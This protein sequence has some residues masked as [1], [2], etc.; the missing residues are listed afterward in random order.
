MKTVRWPSTWS[1]PDWASS[2]MTKMQVSFHW[3]LCRDGLD[4][5][6]QRQVVVGHHRPGRGIL[7]IDP[8]GVVAGQAEDHQ[9]GNS[10]APAELLVLANEDV[11]AMLVALQ[12]RPVVDLAIDVAA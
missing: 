11:G 8:L 4:H 5:A 12:Q 9:V 10:V 1:G 7:G 3:G 2:S 6:A